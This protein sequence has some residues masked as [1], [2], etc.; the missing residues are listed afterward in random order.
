MGLSSKGFYSRGNKTSA[1]IESLTDMTSGDTV[2]DTT[3]Q[4]RRVYDGF[5]WVSGNQI[6]LLSRGVTAGGGTNQ[7]CGAACAFGDQDLAVISGVATANNE[8]VIGSLQTSAPGVAVTIGNYAIVQYRGAGFIAN[9]LAVSVGNNTFAD[10][11]TT[12]GRCSVSSSPTQ[13][14]VMGI[15]LSTGSATSAIRGLIQPIEIN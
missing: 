8:N 12:P 13:T 2:F 7:L 11:S 5:N 4:E 15:W 3:R 1:Q 6:S 10:L 14:G 9:S